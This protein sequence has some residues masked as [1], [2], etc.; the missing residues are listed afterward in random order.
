MPPF[1]RMGLG[2]IVLENIYSQYMHANVFEITMEDPSPECQRVRDYIDARN[3]MKLREFGKD[4]IK[5][6]FKFVYFAWKLYYNE[7]H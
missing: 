1:Q 5:K 4:F 2:S 3:C 6:G 7:N